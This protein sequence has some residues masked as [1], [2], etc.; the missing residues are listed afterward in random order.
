MR[1]R[2]L[3]TAAEARE[4]AGPTSAE[5]VDTALDK[6]RE[7]ANTKK[8]SMAP[9]DG[10]WPSGSYSSDRSTGLAKQYDEAVRQLKEL[11]TSTTKSGSSWTCTPLWNGDQ[12]NCLPRSATSAIGEISQSSTFPQLPRLNCNVLASSMVDC[13]PKMRTKHPSAFNFEDGNHLVSESERIDDVKDGGQ[14][15]CHCPLEPVTVDL[16][17]HDMSN[18]SGIWINALCG[19]GVRRHRGLWEI[20]KGIVA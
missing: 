14:M 6:I 17:P 7:A 20:G 9:H 12:M 5:R 1:A 11:A 18:P 4:I 13:H 16:P 8:R 19:N 10:P 15:R 3:L 2:K